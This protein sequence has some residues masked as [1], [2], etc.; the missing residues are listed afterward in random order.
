MKA[1][2]VSIA[3]ALA[4]TAASAGEETVAPQDLEWV[5]IAPGVDFAAAY[6]D[7]MN[8]AHGKY[9]RFAS[10]TVVPMHTHSGSYRSV[11][12]S[13]RLVNILDEDEEVELGSGHYFHMAGGRVHGHRCV[14]DVPCLI[15]TYSDEKWDVQLVDA[16]EG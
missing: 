6:G 13:G 2:L 9:V 11:V 15:Y 10:G 1:T 8:Q 16:P 14:S 12:L 7:W 4:A 3:I 5:Q